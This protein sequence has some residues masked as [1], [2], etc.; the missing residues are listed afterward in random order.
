MVSGP[1]MHIHYTPQTISHPPIAMENMWAFQGIIS[2][3][4][5]GILTT[6]PTFHYT[7]I[8]YENLKIRNWVN[9][10]IG[11]LI[12]S[13]INKIMGVVVLGPNNSP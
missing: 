10:T 1:K 7:T 4:E 5:F 2:H 11:I 8:S 3:L 13:L 12:D 6:N 9:K